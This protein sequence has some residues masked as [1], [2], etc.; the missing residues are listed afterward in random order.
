V[1]KKALFQDTGKSSEHAE[2][3][4][5]PLTVKVFDIFSCSKHPQ[6]NA[7][8]SVVDHFSTRFKYGQNMG[9][10]DTVCAKFVT[11]LVINSVSATAQD[12]YGRKY[13]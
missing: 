12:Q 9:T 13:T 3:V 5:I 1:G 8:S 10:P 6:F 2:A 4:N 11:D 7:L